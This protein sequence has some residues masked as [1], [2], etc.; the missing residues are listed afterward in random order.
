MGAGSSVGVSANGNGGGVENGQ[1]L[2]AAMV[3]AEA[4]AKVLESYFRSGRLRVDV[5][6]A[7]DFV[8]QA[9]RESEAALVAEILARF[10][11]HRI[12]AEEGTVHESAT[13]DFEWVI[14]PLDGTT[15]FLQGLPVW[16]ISIACRRGAELLAAVVL[17]PQGGNLFTASRGGG[18]YWN[19]RPVHVSARASLDGAFLATGY[20]FRARAALDLY[21]EMFRSVFAHSRAIR[22]CGAAALDLAYTAAGVYDG[23]FEFRLSPWDIAAGALLIEEAGGVLS[24][25]DGRGG[26]LESG[27]VLAGA[28][29][30][31]AGLV[32][33]A[34]ACGAR[35]SALDVLVPRA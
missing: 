30:V 8:T 1:L 12:L 9:D 16:A 2:S 28:P 5:K 27:N 14:D 34:R 11:D 24:D 3:A 17:D 33:S 35:E 21:L 29:G 19:G 13:A 22:R 7:H 25:F 32:E 31:H 15:N 6:G 4:G 20:P 26:Y 10:P 18:A 23:F